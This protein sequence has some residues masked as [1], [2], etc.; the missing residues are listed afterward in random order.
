MS[1]DATEP[2]PGLLVIGYGNELRGDDG[3]GLHVARAVQTLGLP[4]VKVLA[5]SQLTPEIAAEIASAGM[6][7][8]V[9]ASADAELQ[10]FEIRPLAPGGESITLGHAAGPQWLLSL[11]RQLYGQ[12]LPARLLTLAAPKIDFGEE[13]SPGCQDAVAAAVQ[14]ILSIILSAE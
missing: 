13:L 7:L 10:G 2:G 4:G 5:V 14:Y 11:T 6:V 1:D 9:D 3:A 12:T 8:F